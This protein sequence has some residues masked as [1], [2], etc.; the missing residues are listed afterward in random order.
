MDK[1]IEL[2]KKFIQKL[3]DFKVFIVETSN[4]KKRQEYFN[5]NPK[6]AKGLR[7]GNKIVVIGVVLA[8]LVYNN[9]ETIETAQKP[10]VN[11]VSYVYDSNQL[12]GVTTGDDA[13]EVFKDWEQKRDEVTTGADNE[14]LNTTVEYAPSF[15]SYS[16]SDIDLQE[17]VTDNTYVLDQGYFL[18]IDN[19]YTYFIQDPAEM[20]YVLDQTIRSLLPTDALFD[21]YKETGKIKEFKEGKN[22]I[23]N[24]EIENEISITENYVPKTEII[25]DQDELLF[26]LLHKDQEP[27]YYEMKENDTFESVAKKYDMTIESLKLN[28]PNIDE[29]TLLYTGYKLVVNKIDP[30]LKIAKTYKYDEKEKI[31]YQTEY[32]QDSTMN[33]G[34]ESV[35]RKGSNGS[36][37]L[38]YVV[39]EVNGKQIYEKV[40]NVNITSEPVNE[41]IV[42]GTYEPP[43]VGSGQLQMP[44]AGSIICD[45]SCYAGHKGIDIQAWYGAPLYAADGG[46]VTYAGYESGYGFYVEIDHQNGMKTLY[47]H[48]SQ[49]P[50]V[51][52]GQTVDKGQ[53]IGYE[54]ETGNAFGHHVHFEVYVNGSR[55]N[56]QSYL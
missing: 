34:Q 36:K 3:V 49:S 5:S 33:V 12:I 7:I 27:V 48:M 38:T 29:D 22:K 42:R 9:V 11:E 13:S 26:K 32:K 41:I 37:T 46:V 23:V 10:L 56:P 4:P 31:S 19:K 52:A 40:D 55:V 51:S 8:V 54:G 53:V 16:A 44:S 2:F 6:Y 43:G 30:I 35:E 28:N 18:K 1:Y 15:L 14:N 20:Q 24:I 21:Y 45:M 47:A 50:S 17:Y 25:K 39:K